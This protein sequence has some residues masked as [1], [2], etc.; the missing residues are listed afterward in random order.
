MLYI[1]YVSIVVV[2]L[3]LDIKLG[4]K[5]TTLKVSLSYLI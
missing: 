2:L 3:S 5:Y 1:T 4:Y